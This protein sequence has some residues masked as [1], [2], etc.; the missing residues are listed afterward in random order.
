M[1]GLKIDVGK[2]VF[3]VILCL[4]SRGLELGVSCDGECACFGSWAKTL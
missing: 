3:Y 1:Y 4:E 2:S